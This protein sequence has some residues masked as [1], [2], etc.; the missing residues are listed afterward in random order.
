M[1]RKHFGRVRDACVTKVVHVGY[2]HPGVNL[3]Y[4]LGPKR[5]RKRKH[6]MKRIVGSSV[7]WRPT[8]TQTYQ[9]MLDEHIEDIVYA[10]R[11]DDPCKTMSESRSLTDRLRKP[12]LYARLL[13]EA[14]KSRR[15]QEG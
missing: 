3:E 5:M 8:C 1:E 12:P 11:L 10:D 4:D 14:W 6:F 2:D 13:T 7:G 9:R 15:K